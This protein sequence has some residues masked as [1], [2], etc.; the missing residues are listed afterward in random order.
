MRDR[1]GALWAGATRG[2][3]AI[4]VLIVGALA[5]ITALHYLSGIHMLRYHSVYRSLYYLPI[6][7]AAVAFGLRGGLWVSLVVIALN[8]PPLLGV[9]N[10]S[11][12][13]I[14]HMLEVPLFLLVGVLIGLL[15]D[16]ERL[17]RRQ[18]DRLRGYISAV[19]R[20]LPLGVATCGP[21]ARPMAQNPAAEALLDALPADVAL[22]DMAPGYQT[23]DAGRRPLGVH[24]S[25]LR[26]PESA[27]AER[28]L[29]IEDLT[30]RRALEAQLRRNDRLASVGQ[31]AAGIAHEVRNPL[32]IL[33]ATAQLLAR[34]MGDSPGAQEYTRVLITE[35]DRIDRL[36]GE[37]LA[38][39]RPNPPQISR[40]DLAAL[41]EDAAREVRPYALQHEV[42]VEVAAAPV[43]V[44]ADEQ[45]LQQA[46]LNLLLNAVQASQAG[47]QVRICGERAGA[48]TRIVVAD[49]GRGMAP[50]VI[51]RACD[52][53]FTTRPD[54]T[55]LGLALVAA[56]IAEHQG[57]LDFESG[58]G[59]GTRVIIT[60]PEEGRDGAGSGDR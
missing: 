60:L 57:G 14:E 3:R 51:E 35:V 24:I 33:R 25:P 38:Y 22:A 10:T 29:V 30:E 20:S 7:G 28:V 1:A 26:A 42:R 23:F 16:R 8:I 18:V 48:A 31:L 12:E 44:W 55:G 5:L 46:L 59:Q 39:A 11:G 53:F 27:A 45:Q 9:G 15:V 52:P 40:H 43:P 54:G 19:L 37:L 47:G 50:D 2:R 36:I 13:R 34:R 56:V 58:P 4:I 21:D 17:Q 6:A 32:G 49:S 41:L